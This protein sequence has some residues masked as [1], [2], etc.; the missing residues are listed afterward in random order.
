MEQHNFGDRKLTS[1]YPWCGHERYITVDQWDIYSKL[2][3]YGQPDHEYPRD[4]IKWLT[5]QI[6]ELKCK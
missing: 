1:E 4:C 3:T 2:P 6:K 5:D